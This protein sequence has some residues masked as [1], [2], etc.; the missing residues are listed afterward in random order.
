VQYVINPNTD[1][2]VRNGL[3]FQLRFETAF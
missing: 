1:H 3:A 2:T